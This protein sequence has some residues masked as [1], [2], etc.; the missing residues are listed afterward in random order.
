MEAEALRLIAP[1]YVYRQHSPRRAAHPSAIRPTNWRP[2]APMI[3]FCHV[4]LATFPGNFRRQA[5]FKVIANSRHIVRTCDGLVGDLRLP[6]CWDWCKI[7]DN[8]SI[9]SEVGQEKAGQ[10][11]NYY[12][13]N[14]LP[15]PWS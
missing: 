14:N 4:I 10:T 3:T 8:R 7:G 1:H 12:R 6:R 13:F 15:G 2:L 5:C 9:P 11:R